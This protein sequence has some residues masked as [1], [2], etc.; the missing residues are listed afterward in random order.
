MFVDDRLIIFPF[1][2]VNVDILT[3]A[4][5]QL[6]LLKFVI[7]VRFVCELTIDVFINETRD[8]LKFPTNVT[9]DVLY[10]LSCA[11]IDVFI[12]ETRDE[13]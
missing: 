7:E 6:L 9:C 11:I 8:E 5:E 2:V 10:K 13:L 12:N 3:N 4:N 1:L